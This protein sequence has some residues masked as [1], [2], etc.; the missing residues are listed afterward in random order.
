MSRNASRAILIVALVL[1]A[2]GISRVSAQAVEISDPIELEAHRSSTIF[3]SVARMVRDYFRYEAEID[4]S[5]P[6]AE[7]AGE[8]QNSS[9]E[10]LIVVDETGAVSVNGT[11]M[12]AE[13]LLGRLEPIAAQFPNQSVILRGG[14]ETPFKHVISVLDTCQKAGIWNVAFAA[15]PPE[16]AP[17]TP[18]EP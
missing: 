2:T 4:I 16:E 1:S 13:Q 12:T 9:A 11:E 5:L 6:V 7:T 14:E 17:A 18:L 10:I 8:A 3:E 15:K